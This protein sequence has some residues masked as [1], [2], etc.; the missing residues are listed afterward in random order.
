MKKNLLTRS[1]TAARLAAGVLAVAMVVTSI[2]FVPADTEAAKKKVTKVSITKPDTSVLVLKKGK[3]YKIKKKVTASKKKYKGVTFKSSK[4]KIASVSKSGKIK[5]RKKGKTVIT[6]TSKVNKRKKARL[7][8]RVGTPVTKVTLTGSKGW[9][10]TYYKTVTNVET[11][12]KSQK[13]YYA[14]KS[15]AAFSKKSNASV[16]IEKGQWVTLKGNFTPKK[17]TYR[18]LKF[19][20]SNKKVV[21]VDSLGVARAKG[22]GT[23]KVTATSKDG[24]G[25]KAT[26]TI[27]VITQKAE[28]TAAPEY[29]TETRTGVKYEDFESYP[30]GYDWTKEER[31]TKGKEYINGNCG[32]MQVVQDPENAANKVLRIQYNGN[33]QAYDFAPVFSVKLGVGKTMQN[34]SAIRLKTRTVSNSGD[35]KYKA[36]YTYFDQKDAIDSNYYFA[37]TWTKP[38]NAT[39]EDVELHKFDVNYPMAVGV[40]KKY[41]VRGDSTNQKTY[42]NKYFP[43]YYDAWAT[44]KVEKNRTI[45]YKESESEKVGFMTNVLNFDTGIINKADSTLMA[46]RSFDMVLGSTFKGIGYK[47]GESLTIYIDDIEFLEGEIPLTSLNVVTDHTDTIAVGLAT[48]LQTECLPENSTQKEVIWKS[49]NTAIATVDETTGVVQGKSVGDVTITATS[50]KNP[51]FTKSITMHVVAA[52]TAATEDYNVDLTKFTAKKAE[53]NETNAE[54][55]AHGSDVLAQA[56]AQGIT[57]PFT[58]NNQSIVIALPQAMDLTSYKGISITGACDYQVS[59]ELYDDTFD[60]RYSVE[61]ED[62]KF[63]AYDWYKHYDWGTY[64]FFEGSCVGRADDGTPTAVKGTETINYVWYSP[65]KSFSSGNS[66]NVTGSLKKVKYI[67]IKAN[68]YAANKTINI[69]SIKFLHETPTKKFE[70]PAD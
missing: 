24:S 18:K 59:M 21:T 38:A 6:V 58:K 69:K 27:S 25:K 31:T 19:K 34:Y 11:G 5:A 32:T 54:L 57:I 39:A 29:E 20:S 55:Q 12:V 56:A 43:S 4:P 47:A 65:D 35:C 46:Q 60:M 10:Y 49:S 37:T 7:V 15:Q 36:I 16:S 1:K 63:K 68:Q 40:N 9:Q 13:Q 17:A 22:I 42:N 50:K 66:N 70:N 14:E 26:V 53:T 23:A 45:G 8:V 67:V 62:A 44:S 33:T 48:T 64:P 3:T 52:G 2:S 41:N 30:V 51:K 61:S 28:P